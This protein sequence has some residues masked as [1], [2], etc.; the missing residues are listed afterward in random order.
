MTTCKVAI[1][2]EPSQIPQINIESRYHISILEESVARRHRLNRH[3]FEQTPGDGE[4]QGNLACCSP[5]GCKELNMTE[6]Q[7]PTKLVYVLIPRLRQVRVCH[8]GLN[9]SRRLCVVRHKLYCELVRQTYSITFWSHDVL[10]SSLGDREN[11]Q[12]LSEILFISKFKIHY[13]YSS[14]PLFFFLSS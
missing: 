2:K 8:S 11:S 10:P 14:F 4:G 3:E 5:W 13:F 6:Q 1:P 9:K 7:Q 12:N